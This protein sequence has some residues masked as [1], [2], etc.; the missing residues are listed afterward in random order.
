MNV[1]DL[2][3]VRAALLELDRLAGVGVRPLSDADLEAVDREVVPMKVTSVRLTTGQ[4]AELERL[5][6]ALQRLRPELSALARGGE[7]SP[8]TVLRLAIDR[9]LR[10]LARDVARDAGELGSPDA[11]GGAP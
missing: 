5:A 1:V 3:R 8:Y 9:G 11:P 4:E 7:L 6:E 2:P 10:E